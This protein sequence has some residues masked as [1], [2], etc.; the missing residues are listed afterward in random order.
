MSEHNRVIRQAQHFLRTLADQE[1]YEEQTYNNWG[2][3]AL[4]RAYRASAK[5]LE[6]L[7]EPEE[8]EE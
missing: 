6:A 1:P 5:K 2:E 8:G 4:A 7:L 3:S